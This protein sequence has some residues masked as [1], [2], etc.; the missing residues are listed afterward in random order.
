M[1]REGSWEG[2]LAHSQRDG[3]RIFVASRWTLWSDARGNPLGF[4][5]LNTD[6]TE[7]KRAEES[8]RSLSAR[9]LTMQSGAG[10]RANCT[11]VQDR[12]WWR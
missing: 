9:L 6:I 1:L 4:Q 2:E 3:T 12:Y 10:S 7:R 8:L 11:T 5:E